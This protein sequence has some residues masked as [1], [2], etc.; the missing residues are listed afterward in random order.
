M[1]KKANKEQSNTNDSEII[2]KARE[3]NKIVIGFNSVMRTLKKEKIKHI[4]VAQNCPEEQLEKVLDD[5]SIAGITVKVYPGSS[6]DLGV[7]C[8]KPHSVSVLGIC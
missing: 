6:I 4:F 1:A 8:R 3:D 7:L 2:K 5:A